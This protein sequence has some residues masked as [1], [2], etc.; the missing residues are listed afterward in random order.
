MSWEKNR[1][2]KRL[3]NKHIKKYPKEN[4]KATKSPV[5]TTLLKKEFELKF[6]EA[7][8]TFTATT[9]VDVAKSIDNRKD[10][11]FRTASVLHIRPGP[12]SK[13]DIVLEIEKTKSAKAIARR[14]LTDKLLGEGVL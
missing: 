14:N 2:S 7:C 3:R 6:S 4:K 10:V 8:E 13:A 1:S 11:S 12:V 5:K 9:E